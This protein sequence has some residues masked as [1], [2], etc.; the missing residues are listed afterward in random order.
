MTETPDPD[1]ARPATTTTQA[2]IGEMVERHLVESHVARALAAQL[3]APTPTPGPFAR[4]WAW[5]G[6]VFAHPLVVTILGFVLTSGVVWYLDDQASKRTEAAS[7]RAI[8][9]DRLIAWQAQEVARI[10]AERDRALAS[11]RGLNDVIDARA[12]HLKRYSYGLH[13]L[14]SA[15]SNRR[16][17]AYDESVADW[18]LKFPTHL[19]SLHRA[20]DVD[21]AARQWRIWRAVETHVG[22]NNL[23]SAHRCL[24]EALAAR[25]QKPERLLANHNCTNG[26]AVSAW[27]E[28]AAQGA[29]ACS[30]ALRI[31]GRDTILRRAEA[32]LVRLASLEA[33][34]PDWRQIEAG[35]WRD[36]EVGPLV[37]CGE[38]NE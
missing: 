36:I 35:H 21:G 24:M 1:A 33:R 4:L 38:Q 37:S 16:A 20:L 30:I 5:L 23:L 25:A 22:S 34:N 31:S 26:V 9:Q 10:E 2:Q 18:N 15:Q 6:A 8:A 19:E 3:S 27:V 32:Q 29:R 28:A 7:A 12:F 11:L 14:D 13:K 17:A